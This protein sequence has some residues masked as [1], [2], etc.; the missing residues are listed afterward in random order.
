VLEQSQEEGAPDPH[1]SWPPLS[2]WT[3]KAF[4]PCQMSTLR[5]EGCA[6]FRQRIV[7]STL[8]GRPLVIKG[9]RAE[10][11]APGLRDFEGSFLRLIE[12]ITNGCEVRVVDRGGRAGQF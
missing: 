10:E 4:R 2:L 5:Y 7:V 12:K 11:E 8:S 6:Q 1:I 9:I 3:L